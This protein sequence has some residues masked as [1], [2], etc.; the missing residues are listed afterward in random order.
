[1]YICAANHKQIYPGVCIFNQRRRRH[2]SQCMWKRA[3]PSY[4]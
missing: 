3:S 4:A 2:I 1:M